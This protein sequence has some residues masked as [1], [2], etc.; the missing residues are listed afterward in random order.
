MYVPERDMRDCA[1]GMREALS[2]KIYEPSI[3]RAAYR[4]F[5]RYL[6]TGRCGP[7]NHVIDGGDLYTLANMHDMHNLRDWMVGLIDGEAVA[8]AAQV[9]HVCPALL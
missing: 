3:S 6:Y 7:T 5:L 9:L 1:P 8:A 4:E 2:C